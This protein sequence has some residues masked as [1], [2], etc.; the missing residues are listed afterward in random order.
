MYMRLTKIILVI[1]LCVM[2]TGSAVFVS[3]DN[4]LLDFFGGDSGLLVDRDIDDDEEYS[5]PTT[6]YKN[7]ESR[8]GFLKF[9]SN[10][11]SFNTGN[12]ESSS[13]DENSSTPNTGGVTPTLN[14]MPDKVVYAE[15][16]L[17]FWQC[18]DGSDRAFLSTDDD[19]S[20]MELYP[21]DFT[22]IYPTESKTY[23]IDCSNGSSAQCTIDVID[24]VI[25]LE[26]SETTVEAWDNV[27]IR[28]ETS[29][30][31]SCVLNSD[32]DSSKYANWS[33]RG[34]NSLTGIYSHA[35]TKDTVFTLICTTLTG[36]DEEA[37]VTVD[38]E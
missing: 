16:A 9:V 18:L 28:W 26:V 3:A 35:I 19:D 12:Y 29:D 37:S 27:I 14:C 36:L 2:F 20:S 5:L 21:A 25:A 1:A 34:T 23:F 38:V 32:D 4:V 8:S 13:T 24:P 31:Q 30:I 6:E 11:F 7:K 33:R 10:L 15:P 17:I 22:R